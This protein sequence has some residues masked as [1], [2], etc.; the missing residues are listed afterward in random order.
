MA[1][2]ARTRR[3][4]PR[5]KPHWL[6]LF[7]GYIDFYG[8]AVPDETIELTFARLIEARDLAG[9]VAVDA[10]DMPTGLAHLLFHRSTW[11]ATCYCYLEDLYVEPKV[12]GAG[13]GRALIEAAGRQA[14]ARGASRFYWVT[15]ESNVTARRLYD[16]VATLAPFVQYRR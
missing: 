16:T 5:D 2:K 13:V 1:A 8:A 12:R 10:Q 15:Q 6:A 3:L 4:E 9:I 14:D 7:R 11:S